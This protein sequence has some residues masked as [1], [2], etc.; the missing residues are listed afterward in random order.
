MPAKITKS[1]KKSP[2]LD[3][4]DGVKKASNGKVSINNGKAS[5]NGKASSTFTKAHLAAIISNIPQE[6]RGTTFKNSAL[7]GREKFAQKI[8]ALMAKKGT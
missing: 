7:L 6:W 4:K 8:L 2:K 5:I 1:I 3:K